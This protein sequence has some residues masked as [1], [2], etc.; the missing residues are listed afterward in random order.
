MVMTPLTLFVL[1]LCNFTIVGLAALYCH[2]VRNGT[3]GSVLLSAMPAI[4]ALISL[5]PGT[6][7][8]AGVPANE[9][10][11]AEVLLATSAVIGS[12]LSITLSAMTVAARGPLAQQHG[13]SVDDM[14]QYFDCLPYRHVRHPLSSA[15]LLALMAA[16]LASPHPVMLC[17]LVYA[18]VRFSFL[19][20]C[21]ERHLA[22]SAI[23]PRY[24]RYLAESGRFFPKLHAG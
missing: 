11:I 5:V 22:S 10:A 18:C 15:C 8:M 7:A 19:A 24:R 12:T 3:I 9:F 21:E 4:V 1:L 6:F 2:R 23:G 16:I 13:S 20:G 17:C 14:Q